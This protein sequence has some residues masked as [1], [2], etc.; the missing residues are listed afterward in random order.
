MS[1]TRARERDLD[2]ILYSRHKMYEAYFHLK[3]SHSWMCVLCSCPV[4]SNGVCKAPR[5]WKS[6]LIMSPP[7]QWHVWSGQWGKR[8]LGFKSVHS[9]FDLSLCSRSQSGLCLCRCRCPGCWRRPS[10]GISPGIPGWKGERA[11]LRW[12][13]S[14]RGWIGIEVRAVDP[15]LVLGQLMSR[16]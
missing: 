14:Y 4:K 13:L 7:L 10:H 15:G 2:R 1:R 11:L 9:V 12:R 6:C 3:F 8:C 16:G 5:L